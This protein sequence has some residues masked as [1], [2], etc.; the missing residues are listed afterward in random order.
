L[1]EALQD[2]GA[3]AAR[4]NQPLLYEPLNRYETNVFNRIGEACAFLRTLKT[5]SVKIVADLFHMN[6]EEAS[7]VEAIAAAKEQ[8][9]HVHFADSNRRAAGYGHLAFEPIIRALQEIGYDGY[10]SAEVFPLPDPLSAARQ[11]ISSFKTLT[12]GD[13]RNDA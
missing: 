4:N 1:G 5:T 8:I 13:G 11:T 12:G 9:G 2:L 6:I 3:H 10:L 7:M